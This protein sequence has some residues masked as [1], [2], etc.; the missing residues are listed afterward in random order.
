LP[1][2][3]R[4]IRLPTKTMLLIGVLTSPSISATAD[5]PSPV[6]LRC[7]VLLRLTLHP[8][9]RT[10]AERISL[11]KVYPTKKI[12]PPCECDEIAGG[13]LCGPRGGACDHTPEQR[14]AT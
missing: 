8:R 1:L 12:Q 9:G 10:V 13:F 3:R 11:R 14:P 5:M 7:P 6:L 2:R 4:H